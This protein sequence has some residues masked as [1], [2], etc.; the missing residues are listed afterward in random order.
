MPD[1]DY[2]SRPVP[3]PSL[4]TDWGSS[5][6]SGPTHALL[7]CLQTR[8]EELGLIILS[9]TN[10]KDCSSHRGPCLILGMWIQGFP[11]QVPTF[12]VQDPKHG[13]LH[14]CFTLLTV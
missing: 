8:P 11:D 6:K 13:T 3:L 7:S 12:P 9:M 1:V 2:L 5:T 4:V 14:A 10:T